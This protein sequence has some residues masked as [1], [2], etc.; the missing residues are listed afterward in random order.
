MN[1]SREN[2]S[3]QVEGVRE[4]VKGVWTFPQVCS[5]FCCD[6]QKDIVVIVVQEQKMILCYI[7]RLCDNRESAYDLVVLMLYIK[8][9]YSLNM[10]W[11]ILKLLR[12]GV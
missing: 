10:K 9:D 4:A 1:R 7:Q 3:S 12:G 11:G 8:N 6:P 5:I 2:N